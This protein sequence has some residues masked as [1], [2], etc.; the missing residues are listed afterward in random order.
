MAST[1]HSA[2]ANQICGLF[3]GLRHKMYLHFCIGLGT[4]TILQQRTT[5]T[6]FSI[7]ET[8]SVSIAMLTHRNVYKWLVGS[9][10][11]WAKQIYNWSIGYLFLLLL[12]LLLFL[13]NTKLWEIHDDIG[14]EDKLAKKL[15]AQTTTNNLRSVLP[16]YSLWAYSSI[17][18]WRTKAERPETNW[19][20]QCTFHCDPWRRPSC[21][22]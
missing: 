21:R 3:E 12:L 10:N 7:G 15:L 4:I 16:R 8:L 13:A 9:L 6:S 22:R 17:S 14:A 18:S 19:C 2:A 11:V 20:R 5:C 1:L